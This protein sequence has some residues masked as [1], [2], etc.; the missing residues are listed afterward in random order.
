MMIV[1]GEDGGR[2]SE[3]RT[4]C[5]VRMK[6]ILCKLQPNPLYTLHVQ[7]MP[8]ENENIRTVQN[9]IELTLILVTGCCSDT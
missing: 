3:L 9:L 5:I 7:I 6:I 4:F 2:T 8:I 1:K